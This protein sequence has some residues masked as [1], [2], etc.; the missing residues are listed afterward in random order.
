MPTRPQ[1][2]SW[3]LLIRHAEMVDRFADVLIAKA[4]GKNYRAVEL[5]KEY[6]R[7]FGKY[8]WEIQRYY[9]HCLCCRVLEHI[10]RRPQGIIID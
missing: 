6:E 4:T 8:E 5:A 10:T 7:E 2:V 1:T 3:R 9:D